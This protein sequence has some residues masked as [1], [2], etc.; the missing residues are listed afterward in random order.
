MI[1][2]R[3]Q[4]LL[5]IKVYSDVL[6]CTGKKY[7]IIPEDEENFF[8][9]SDVNTIK[10]CKDVFDKNK[11]EILDEYLSF[12]LNKLTDDELN[13]IES[14]RH[15][16]YAD[17]IIVKCLKNYAVFYHAKEN[18]FYAV[19]GL[20]TPIK[21]FFSR[22]PVLVETTILPLSNQ[23]VCDGLMKSDNVTIG[24]YIAKSIHQLYMD[25]KK[26]KK[27]ITHF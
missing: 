16:I 22:F 23:I 11:K 15:S 25:A 14:L 19:K 7:C 17:F 27:I 6:L 3:K 21:E 26:N 2:S 12:R 10:Q 24:F 18:K 5:F 1:V 9:S 8:D 20:T 4:S 13:I